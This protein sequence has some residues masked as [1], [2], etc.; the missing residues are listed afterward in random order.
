[1]IWAVQNGYVDQV[2]VERV[3]KFQL[4]LTEF[5][6]TRQAGLLARIGNEKSLSDALKAELKSAID[7]FDETW[8]ASATR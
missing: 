6:T 1:V 8:K 7:E 2:A 4:E 5:L 3:K